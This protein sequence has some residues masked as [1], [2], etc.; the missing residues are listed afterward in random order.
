MSVEDII[1]L[2]I[3]EKEKNKKAEDTQRIQIQIPIHIEDHPPPSQPK[4]ED[5]REQK[6][7]EE[8]YL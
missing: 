2:L 3:L 7:C 8:F 1:D 4:E 5:A 6:W